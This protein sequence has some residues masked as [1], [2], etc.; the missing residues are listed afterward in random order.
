MER[1]R[2][3]T[4]L[5][6]P[7]RTCILPLSYEDIFTFP[8]HVSQE[9]YPPILLFSFFSEKYDT[10]ECTFNIMSDVLSIIIA[11]GCVTKN[12]ISLLLSPYVFLLLQFVHML[13]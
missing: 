4:S 2:H 3:A 6:I 13:I 10:S 7:H 12:Q 8:R 1:E 9:E 11:A 5:N